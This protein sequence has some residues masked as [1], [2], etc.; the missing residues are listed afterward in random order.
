VRRLKNRMYLISLF[1]IGAF[2]GSFLNVCIHRMPREESI[3]FP[4]SHCPH[5]NHRLGVIDLIPIIGYFLIRGTCGYCQAAVSFRYPL[6][7]TISGGVFV[8]SALAFPPLTS[9]F[10]FAFSLIFLSLLIVIFFVDLEHQV[11]PS[12]ASYLGVAVGLL[13]NLS[14]GLN[15]FLSALI[16]AG[17]GFFIL[18]LIGSV[19]K[20]LFKKDAM[21]EGDLYLGA[22]LGAAFGWRGLWLALFLAYLLAAIVALVLLGFGKVKMGDYVPFGPA[23]AAGG[24]ITLFFGQKILVWYLGMFL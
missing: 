19:G 3:V 14:G 8:A 7:E 18:Y 23:L 11:I 1:I 10:A 15:L 13:F 9:S 6:V 22:M 17:L 12:V 20:M 24:V 4:G 5:C 21:G 2:V 16:G